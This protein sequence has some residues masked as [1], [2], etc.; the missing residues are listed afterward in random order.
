MKITPDLFQAY[1]KCPTKCWLRATG[2]SSSGNAY[3]E[4]VNTQ[5]ESYR[6][7]ETERLVAE[8]PNGEVATSPAADNLKVAR[9]RLALD[10]PAQ[11]EL[12]SSR[13]NETQTSSPEISQRLLTSAATIDTCLHAVERVPS[14]GRGK[15]AQIIPI[16]F[17]FRNK[18]TKDDKLLLT[19][20]AFVLSEILGREVKFGKIIHGDDR[21]CARE[22]AA[23]SECEAVG[24]RT[25]MTTAAFSRAQPRITKVKTSA[26]AG[27]VRKH[28]DKIAALFSSSVP[29]DLVL[30]RHCAECEF[31][32]RCRKIAVE[33]DDLS[34]LAGMSAKERERHRSKGIFTVNQLSYTFRP[35]RIPKRTKHPAKPHHFALQALAIRENKVYIHGTPEIPEC[36]TQVY[37]DI[38]GLWLEKTPPGQAQT[39]GGPLS[40]IDGRVE[41]RFRNC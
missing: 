19:F 8:S 27:E 20:D 31:Q 36:K 21:G 25:E 18:L 3:A 30:N 17:I 38:E 26:L 6:I 22:S 29:P 24:Q 5:N 15:A 13:G 34:L 35:R 2:E 37:L 7:T 9:W 10:V 12:R 28:L 23:N 16:R 11:I 33:K 14:E 41:A 4:W 39:R 32:A 40:K 1:L